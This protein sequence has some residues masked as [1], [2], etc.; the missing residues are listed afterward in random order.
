MSASA[1]PSILASSCLFDYLPAHGRT[2]S[3]VIRTV[4]PKIVIL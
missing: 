4:T 3:V 2:L 1:V